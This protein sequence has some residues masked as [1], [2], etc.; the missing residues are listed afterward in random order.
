MIITNPTEKMPMLLTY[1]ALATQ[2]FRSFRLRYKRESC[3][4]C[5]S[6]SSNTDVLTLQ[7]DY[8]AF[9]GGERPDPVETGAV[10]RESR[11]RSQDLA[12]A[13][14]DEKTSSMI[15]VRTPEEFSICHLPGSIN[16]TM[17]DVLRDPASYTSSG[18]KIYVVCRLGNDSQIAAEALRRA[19]SASDATVLDLIGGLR[20]WSNEVDNGF[21]VY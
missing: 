4:A 15:D 12:A 7:E 5:C 13:L 8:V 20:A 9:C 3:I 14:R 16:V 10:L 18:K 11:L 21:P 1:S 2:P 17:S 19:A 6:G